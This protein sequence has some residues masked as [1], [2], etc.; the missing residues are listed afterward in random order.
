MDPINPIVPSQPD[1]GPVGPMD[2][3]APAHRDGARDGGASRR[4]RRRRPTAGG[5]DAAVQID[6]E[7]VDAGVDEPGTDGRP[8]VDVTV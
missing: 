1:V 8:H 2:R 4:D 6:V 3:L 5:D 7:G